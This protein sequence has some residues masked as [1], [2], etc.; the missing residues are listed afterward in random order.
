MNIVTKSNDIDMIFN[1]KKVNAEFILE[2]T[3]AITSSELAVYYSFMLSSIVFLCAFINYLFP[4]LDINAIEVALYSIGILSLW[5]KPIKKYKCEELDNDKCERISLS[6]ILNV[7]DKITPYKIIYDTSFSQIFKILV[8]AILLSVIVKKI[9]NK[10]INVDKL[11]KELGIENV[12]I[13]Y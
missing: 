6:K 4:N 2:N 1:N 5:F 11:R 8:C 10:L 3:I 7:S 13:N 9:F 12:Y